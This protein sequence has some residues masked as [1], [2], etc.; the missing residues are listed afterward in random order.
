MACANFNKFEYFI[1]EIIW[2]KTF[3]QQNEDIKNKDVYKPKLLCELILKIFNKIEN[4][5]VCIV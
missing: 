1:K 4:Y 2:A 3:W 5:V